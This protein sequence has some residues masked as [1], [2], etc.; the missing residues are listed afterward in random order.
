[1]IVTGMPPIDIVLN[2][3]I[4]VIRGS[5]CLLALS[6]IVAAIILYLVDLGGKHGNHRPD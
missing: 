2:G 5:L 1:M 6:L 4:N 3:L